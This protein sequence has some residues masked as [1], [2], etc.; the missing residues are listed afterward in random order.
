MSKTPEADILWYLEQADFAKAATVPITRRELF[1]LGYAIGSGFTIGGL[2]YFEKQ[3]PAVQEI[4]DFLISQIEPFGQLECS[5]EFRDFEFM[6]EDIKNTWWLADGDSVGRGQSDEEMDDYKDTHAIPELL[7]YNVRQLYSLPDNAHFNLF[8]KDPQDA[9][10]PTDDQLAKRIQDFYRKSTT[11]SINIAQNTMPIQVTPLQ[12]NLL[13]KSG[14]FRQ[15]RR[16]KQKIV[17][18]ESDG[19]NNPNILFRDPVLATKAQHLANEP[20]TINSL[21]DYLEIFNDVDQAMQPLTELEYNNI[22]QIHKL[23]EEYNI[24]NGL[25]ILGNVNMGFA[26]GL[27]TPVRTTKGYEVIGSKTSPVL[28]VL[29]SIYSLILERKK[30]EALNQFD[31]DY[32][33]SRL[34]T[35]FYSLYTLL[36]NGMSKWGKTFLFEHPTILGF[37]IL[38]AEAERRIKVDGLRLKE[39]VKQAIESAEE[40]NRFIPVFE[41]S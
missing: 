1:T 41:N 35:Q 3:N 16:A 27:V 9:N 19:G 8:T 32:P 14:F 2:A 5:A 28:R 10:Q 18:F 15:V 33:D 37:L 21:P 36:R 23:H 34:I 29:S 20:F 40:P 13:E 39:L 11:G 24:F 17:I 26:D 6:S 22:V 30:K 25:A 31:N 38:L 7:S 12:I 4:F